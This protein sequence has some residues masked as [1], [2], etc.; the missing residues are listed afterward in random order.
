M[1][2]TDLQLRFHFSSTTTHWENGH[3]GTVGSIQ[4]ST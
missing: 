4:I 2:K 1:P 3:D